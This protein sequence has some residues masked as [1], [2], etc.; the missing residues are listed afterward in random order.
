MKNNKSKTVTTIGELFTF[1]C[2]LLK[3]NGNQ[4]YIDD[5]LL[6][7]SYLLNKKR[8]EIFIN[9]FEIVPANIKAKY[10]QW[11]NKRSKGIP[12]QYITGYQNFMGHDF[13]VRKGVL[14]PRPETEIL[15]EKVIEFIKNQKDKKIFFLL[16]IGVGSGIIP[17]SICQYFKNTNI[18][19]HFYAI[20]ISKKAL[21]IAE[22]NANLF[23]CKD[24]I[25]FIQSNL[26]KSLQDKKYISLFDGIVSNPPYISDLEWPVLADEVAEHE[27]VKALY[28]GKKGLYFYEKIIK[29][30]PRYLNDSNGFLA[31][32]IGHTQKNLISQLILKN[33]C[34]ES[35]ISLFRDY[36]HNYR[37]LFAYKKNYKIKD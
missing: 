23:N 5:S 9:R 32:E 37:I 30:S 13:I 12:V 20:D 1:G 17:V 14:I 19:V 18:S 3:K 24:R 34:Y 31:F 2:D 29:E 22:E 27:P 8:H 7:L 26:F 6:L 21:E 25:T 35:K 28:G 16:D 10:I 15:V 11:I 4:M 36:F 33:P